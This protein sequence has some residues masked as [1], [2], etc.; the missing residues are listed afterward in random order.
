MM[1][2]IQWRA[3]NYDEQGADRETDIFAP[4]TFYISS[5]C[6][7]NDCGSSLESD[8]TGHSL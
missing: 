2:W 7:T 3:D 5:V 4:M 8:V 6:D 1:V